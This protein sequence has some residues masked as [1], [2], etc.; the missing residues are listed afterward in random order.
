M[1]KQLERTSSRDARHK[2]LIDHIGI[3]SGVSGGSVTAA[4]FG[5]R[6]RAALDD[7]RER[8][9]TQDLMAQLNTNVSLSIS[10]AR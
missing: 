3:V 2:D 4:Y 5:L 6:G 1:L 7:F 10:A 9:L 8:F